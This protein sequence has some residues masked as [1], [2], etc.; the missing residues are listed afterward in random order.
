MGKDRFLAQ[1]LVPLMMLT[2]CDALRD[3]SCKG[4]ATRDPGSPWDPA[5]STWYCPRT[6]KPSAVE[7]AV[8][9]T[10]SSEIDIVGLL[11]I[12]L[13]NHPQTK[14]AWSQARAQAFQ[15]GIVD[16]AW[17]PTV[18]WF[19]SVDFVDNTVGGQG[20]I[21]QLA[22]EGLLPP[23]E[24]NIITGGTNVGASNNFVDSLVTISYLLLDCGGRYASSQAAR[25]ALYSL[26]WTQNR[27][28]Q[29][30]IFNVMQ[31]YYNYVG[32]K[33]LLQARYQDLEN[34]KMTLQ[35]A[36][37]QHEA[38]LASI[39]DVLQA[40]SNNEAA[41][42]AVVSAES[43]VKI[44]LGILANAL[45]I[46]PSTEFETKNL[47]EKFPVQEIC[48]GVDGLMELARLNRPDLAAA[49][50]QIVANK[51]NVQAAV[52]SSLPTLSASA[53][54][55]QINFFRDSSLDGHIYTG[56]LTITVPIFSGFLY[57]NQIKQAEENVRAA[58]ANYD[59]IENQALL[60]VV[61]S[62]YNFISAKESLNYAEAF[63]KYSQEAYD[64]A[65]ETYKVG[66]GTI[67]N[68][69]TTQATLANARAQRIQSRT[70]W[71]VSLFNIA[72]A[73]GTI[74]PNFVRTELPDTKICR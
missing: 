61:G 74:S 37:A 16:S 29:Q 3:P 12:A 56:I 55:E 73:T 54:L 4:Q 62:Y 6:Q 71:A 60:D 57:V 2:S 42:L 36:E 28:I 7:A 20:I 50:A 33:E 52:S 32:S 15:V 1:Y 18:T 63:L 43:Q 47:P 39:L 48:E 70:Q 51:Y 22:D 72:F 68:V 5:C 49:E 30:V 66:T 64:A 19:E 11:D 25:Y 23:N 59:I 26:N 67:L 38:G 35:A 44:N 21:S 27:T 34:T 13:R 58:K 9:P 41:Q 40:R 8:L 10:P 31:A 14:F 53:N 24:E 17:Y 46:P 69:L 45:G 65:L